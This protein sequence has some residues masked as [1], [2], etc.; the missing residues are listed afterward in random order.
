MSLAL[1][2]ADATVLEEV[3]RRCPVLVAGHGRVV[4]R[5]PW[6]HRGKGRG[7]CGDGV[8]GCV[9]AQW[10]VGPWSS[11]GGRDACWGCPPLGVGRGATPIQQST[12]RP[13]RGLLQLM[14]WPSRAPSGGG[15]GGVVWAA[16]CVASGLIGSGGGA[17]ERGSLP[18]LGVG[19]RRSAPAP[20]EC[21]GAF[22]GPPVGLW[23]HRVDGHG[24][25][26]SCHSDFPSR[27]SQTVKFTVCER[28][29]G[30]FYRLAQDRR[31]R[32]ATEC[33]RAPCV[34]WGLPWPPCGAVEP[35]G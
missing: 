2:C 31:R 16:S 21:L 13:L 26:H 30:K 15:G 10:P 34:L 25:F 1:L 20:R 32:P 33:P 7:K 19:R 14:P 9:A 29:G 17:T 24:H 5:R 8:G 28:W 18:G 22:P 23:S 12:P 6:E 27:G 11:A 35:S 4:S 3:V